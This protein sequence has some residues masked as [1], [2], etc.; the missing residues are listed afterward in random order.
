MTTTELSPTTVT[1]KDVDLG[2][3]FTPR[4]IAVVGLKDGAGF[5][6][7]F[8]PTMHSDA[9]VFFVNPKYDTVFGQKTYPS[10]TAIGRPIDVVYC[11]TGAEVTTQVAEEAAGLD[12]GGLVLIAGG[13]AEMDQAGAARQ[14][15]LLDAARRGGM[16][17]VGPNGLGYVNVPQHISLT[18]A[19][20]HKRRPG[21]ISVVSQ[22]GALLSGIAMAAWERPSVGLN[23]LVS[24][25]NEA[26]TDLADY[27]DY[28]ADDPATT[29]IALV[30]EKVRR[31]K[32]FFAAVR[33]AMVKGKPVAA[34][35][36]ARSARTQEL[37]ASHTG[38]L[39]GDAWVYDVAFKQA[40]IAIA[41]DPEELVDRLAILE[42][43]DQKYWTEA[44]NVA[45]IT[46]TGGFASI[47]MDIATDEGVNVPPLDDFRDWVSTNLPGVKVPNPLD[48][49]GLGTPI[50][51]EIVD[52]YAG[53][54][55]VDA[56][57]FVHPLAD[58]DEGIGVAV[59]ET[60]I[61]QAEV[62]GKPFIVSNCATSLGTWAETLVS[63]NPGAATGRG[64][65][66]TMRGLQTLGDFVR[67]R[68]KVTADEQRS[69][70]VPR[71]AVATVPQPEGSMLPFA[72]TMKLL[73]NAG[74]P[75]APYAL[76]GEDEEVGDVPFAG[77]YVVKLADVGHRTE[78]GAV[79][80]NVSATDL[81]DAVE[82]M[83]RIAAKDGLA[84]TVAVQPMV[85]AQGEAFLGIQNS[86]LGPMVVFGL[87]GIFVEV[88]R[89]V[90][91]RMAPLS[92]DDAYSL[93]AEF[94]DVKVMHG[95]RGRPA[96]NHV[97]L[98]EI[99]VN[100]GKLAAGATEWVGSLDINPMIVTDDGF[101]AVD[102]L[103][104]VKD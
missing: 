103:C 19:S 21:G 99:L 22:S 104:I 87:G 76:V 43:L 86:E 98:A 100:A 59:T 13:F 38:S 69:A 65:R 90:G 8:E 60:F 33:R 23:L 25:G 64:P 63:K 36:L 55:D 68:A 11:V 97:A 32:E 10:L 37:A 12:V 88:L 41:R 79:V 91:G 6:P 2:R 49:T 71:P 44:A 83:R 74:I 14:E 80:L 28:L 96:W 72:D 56:L 93:I 75:V 46:F 24:A 85:Q 89:R 66:S 77:P 82:K 57:L 39:T 58:E 47:S 30:I 84:P 27:I 20:D 95:F 40:G 4:T 16:G 31:P 53:S 9:E 78:H 94:E 29:A 54:D 81:A 5:A 26:V 34:L 70:V 52:K 3:I 42:Q 73:E 50:W 17:I 7:Y 18:I 15:R 101:L 51:P 67:S 102:A 35:K 48:A 62:V 1:S 45:I 92:T 61:A